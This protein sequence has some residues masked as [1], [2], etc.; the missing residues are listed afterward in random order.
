MTELRS[1]EQIMSA[2]LLQKFGISEDLV[3]THYEPGRA[4]LYIHH[5]TANE[6][7]GRLHLYFTQSF[8]EP[9]F[10]SHLTRAGEVCLEMLHSRG[11]LPTHEA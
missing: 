2:F 7:P 4:R 9:S 3:T 6:E 10:K 11:L 5:I 8:M 1:M